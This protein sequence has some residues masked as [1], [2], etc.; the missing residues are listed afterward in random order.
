MMYVIPYRHFHLAALAIQDAQASMADMIKPEYAK[1]LEAAGP[2]YTVMD[3]QEVIACAGLAEQWPGR[4]TAWSILSKHVAGMKMARLHKMVARFLDMQNYTR[5]EMTVDHEFEQGHRWAKMLGFE[6]E[7]L[8]RKYN[9][10]GV[11]CDLYARVK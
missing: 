10:N 6:W 7:G 9:P 1:A 8:M 5:I 11:D 2:A 4:A 3:N